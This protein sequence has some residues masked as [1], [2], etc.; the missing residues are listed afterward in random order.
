[1]PVPVNEDLLSQMLGMGF[2]D[3]RARKGLVNGSTL[4]GAIAWLEQVSHCIPSHHTTTRM[5]QQSATATSVRATTLTHLVISSLAPMYPSEQ[6]ENDPDIDQ[7]YMVRKVRGFPHDL[8]TWGLLMQR[9][10]A[11]AVPDGLCVPLCSLLFLVCAHVQADTMP[12]KQL[13]AEEKA[14]RLEEMK[15]KIKNR[16]DEKSRD[17]KAAEIKREKERRER[18]QVL[19]ETQEERDRLARKREA[20][21]QKKEKDAVRPSPTISPHTPASMCVCRPVALVLRADLL[22]DIVRLVVFLFHALM[23]YLVR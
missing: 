13:T 19:Q 18:G 12:K 7:P 10:T 4:E 17:E 1:M 15:N 8:S 22:S 14:A 2:S 23:F 16:R 20:E 11:T 3:V 21:R 5:P 6:H 9:D